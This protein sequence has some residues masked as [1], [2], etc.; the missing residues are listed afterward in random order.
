MPSHQR[1]RGNAAHVVRE[2]LTELRARL[3]KALLGLAAA[4]HPQSFLPIRSG[5]SFAD[6]QPRCCNRSDIR[7]N[8]TYSIP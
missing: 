4:L 3:V 5:G 7:P 1:R 8:F 6:P 2:H